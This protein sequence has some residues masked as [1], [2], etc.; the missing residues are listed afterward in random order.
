MGPLLLHRPQLQLHIF[1]FGEKKIERKIHRVLRYG[2]AAKPNSL[3]GGLI[4][5][6]FGAPERGI[7]RRRHHEPTSITNFMML[8]AVVSN[9]IVGLLDGDGLDEIYHV[10]ELV[11]LGFD[12]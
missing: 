12:P 8:A 3:S 7:R 6:P 10:I 1:V 5:S 11:L 2:A 9:S 4:W